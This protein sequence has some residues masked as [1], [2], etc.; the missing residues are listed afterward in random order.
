MLT[1]RRTR[2]QASSGQRISSIASSYLGA[3]SS[4]ILKG[5]AAYGIGGVGNTYLLRLDRVCLRSLAPCL[6]AALAVSLCLCLCLCHCLSL[7]L[8]ASRCATY[9]FP[10]TGTSADRWGCIRCTYSVQQ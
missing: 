2:S 3:T 9:V 4:R 10:G 7:P 6:S 8:S 5:L 1:D